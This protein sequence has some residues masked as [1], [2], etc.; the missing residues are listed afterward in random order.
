MG[1]L[2]GFE[3]MSLVPK[4]GNSLLTVSKS[5]IRFNKA[6]ATELGFP[7]FVKLLVNAKTNQVAIQNCSEKDPAAVPFCDAEKKQNYA[8]FIKIPA[9]L[10]EFRRLLDFEDGISYSMGGITYPNDQVIIYDLKDAKKETSKWSGKKK[11]LSEDLKEESET[12]E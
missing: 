9:L 5:N 2:D 3:A 11:R 10:A 6:T 1:L 7:Q 12:K 8:I 4:K